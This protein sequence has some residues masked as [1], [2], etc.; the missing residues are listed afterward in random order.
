MRQIRLPNG[1]WIVGTV[2]AARKSA[3]AIDAVD[4]STGSAGVVAVNDDVAGG[5]MPLLGAAGVTS[6]RATTNGAGCVAAGAGV[7]LG[8]RVAVGDGEADGAD[9]ATTRGSGFGS[10][11]GCGATLWVGTALGVAVTRDDGDGVAGATTATGED[12]DGGFETGAARLGVG[13]VR[14]TADG[15][16]SGASLGAETIATSAAGGYATSVRAPPASIVVATPR[17]ATATAQAATATVIAS[18]S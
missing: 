10:A 9:G 6:A 8:A 12:A 17:T 15:N 3:A 11:L 4:S 1:D 13:D 5:A 7:A 16:E 14:T 2:N 18:I